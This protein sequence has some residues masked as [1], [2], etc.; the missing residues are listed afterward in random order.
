[1]E[2]IVLFMSGKVSLIRLYDLE[3]DAATVTTLGKVATPKPEPVM[4]AP[5]VKAPPAAT[6]W[7]GG[8]W[9]PLDRGACDGSDVATSKVPVPDEQRCTENM[10]GKVVI[11]SADFGGCFYKSLTPAQ[12]KNGSKPGR[13]YVCAPR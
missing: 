12:C 5:E 9:M 8:G 11:C 6:K 7:V 13:M 4:A 1:M 2:S 10:A 3:L